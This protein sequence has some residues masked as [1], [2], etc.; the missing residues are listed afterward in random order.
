MRTEVELRDIEIFLALAEELHFG[1][2][3]ERLHVTQARVSQS[4]KKQERR[5]GG[6]LFDRTSRAVRL[7]PLGAQLYQ[8]L[9]AGYRQIMDGVA[10]VS[11][12][13]RGT[14]GVL[15]LG[16]IGPHPFGLDDLVEAM[17]SF[18]HRYPAAQLQ[19]REIQPPAPLDP[20]RSGE[21]DVALLWL[22]V[23]E[24]DLTVGPVTH[25][26]PVLLMV[27]ADHPFAQRD[28]ICLED[29]GDCTVVAG[30]SIPHYMEE[31]INPFHTPSGRPIA[32]GPVMSTWQQVVNTVT[33]GQCVA[34]V[35]AEF[36]GY[37]PWPGLAFVPIR[38][39][40]PS[41]WALVWRT[42]AESPLIRAFAETVSDVVGDN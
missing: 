32:R 20:L 31:A 41:R 7:T 9:N 21:V 35:V 25:T 30:D 3:A 1:R 24:P 38:D 22:P 34:G 5:V 16:S 6:A 8:E 19:H 39:A 11:A 40:A 10:S 27:A 18:Q 28:S 13:A 37:Y 42:A 2:T 36:A 12:A 4:I 33:S 14:A 15:T 17:E 29:L 26:S 23:R